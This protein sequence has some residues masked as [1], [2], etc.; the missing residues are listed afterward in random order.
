ME[1]ID[2]I[3]IKVNQ[4]GLEAQP[5]AVLAMVNGIKNFKEENLIKSFKRKDELYKLLS[6]KFSN[7]KKSPTGVMIYPEGLSSEINVPHKLSDDDLAYV[8]SFILLRDYGIITIPP[9]SMPGASATIRFELSSSDAVN[10]DLNSLGKKIV[11]A[12]EKL[13]DI[14]TNEE[15]CREIVFNS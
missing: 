7:F 5:P 10:L 4:F 11:S 12:F 1:L 13:Q 14:I 3:K 9:V 15:K 6:L 2:E 8:F